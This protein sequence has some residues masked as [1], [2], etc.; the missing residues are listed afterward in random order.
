MLKRITVFFIAAILA[1]MPITNAFAAYDGYADV[2]LDGVKQNYTV[3]YERIDGTVMVPIRP[4]FEAFHFKLDWDAGRQRINVTTA[5]GKLIIQI[6]SHVVSQNGYNAYQM[7]TYARIENGQTLIPIEF[8][9]ACTGASVQYVE[10]NNSV[11][12]TSN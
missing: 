1:M 12:I 4:I 11:V 9:A 10:S 2:Y 5:I 8:A 7:S 3:Y 6:G